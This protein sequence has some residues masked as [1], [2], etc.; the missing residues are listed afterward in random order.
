[1]LLSGQRWVS[2]LEI[3]YLAPLSLQI[4]LPPTY[5]STDSPVFTLS[6]SWLSPVHLTALCQNLDTLWKENDHM[7][8]IFT[9]IDWLENNVLSFLGLEDSVII[10]P[11]NNDDVDDPR[12]F[13][14]S[15]DLGHNI[16]S[17]LQYN[18]QQIE[19]EFCRNDQDCGVCFDRLPGNHFY[20]IGNC[21]HHYCRDCMLEYCQ[22]H[23]SAGT[24]ESLKCPDAECNDI[25]PPYI[26][27]SVLPPMAYDRWERLVLQKSLTHMEDI[28]WCPRCSEPVIKEAEDSLNLAH[29]VL[30]FYSFCTECDEVWHQVLIIT[31]EDKLKNLEQKP[32]KVN[33]EA[34]QRRFE[35][36]REKIRAEIESARLLKLKMRN[37][38]K[39]KAK[40]EKI[41]GCNKMTCRCGQSFCWSCGQTLAAGSLGYSHFTNS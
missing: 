7:V 4:S 40:I 15:V 2:T 31:A 13:P 25:I 34:E 36:M 23:V 8:I 21:G 32:G 26:V 24:V 19:V 37:C 35:E 9:W 12:A 30:C 20:R 3:S 38:P 1:L 10:K 22:L 41:A 5:P 14:E 16:I 33:N 6:S 39:C 18:R 11:F 29:C 28:V 27:Q 17:M